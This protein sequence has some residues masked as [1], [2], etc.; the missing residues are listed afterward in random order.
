M[1]R[2]SMTAARKRLAVEWFIGGAILFAIVFFQSV[3]GNYYGKDYPVVWSWLLPNIMPTLS[4]VVAVLVS[5][6]ARGGA[7]ESTVDAFIFWMAFALS[8]AYLLVILLT[9]FATRF[10]ELGPPNLFRA[11]TIWLGPFQG[12]VAAALGAFFLHE[13]RG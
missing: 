12:L 6:H 10:S 2:I 5:E 3:I 1:R 11:S 8:A 9:I 13:E 4:L 7:S